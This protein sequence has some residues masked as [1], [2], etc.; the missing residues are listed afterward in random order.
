MK[1]EDLFT[2]LIEAIATRVAAILSPQL[3]QAHAVK[4]RLLT[5]EQ[6]A[7]YL[8]RTEGAVRQ[9]LN[10]DTFSAVRADGRVMLDIQDLDRWIAAN[11]S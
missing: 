2:L 4:P 1:N 8:G 7:V 10:R 6:A 11:K 5:I 9:L 3:T